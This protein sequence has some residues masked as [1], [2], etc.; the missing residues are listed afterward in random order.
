[1]FARTDRLLLR[2][3]FA[4]DAVE[5]AAAIGD[6]AVV[7]NLARAPWPYG[8]D[9]ARQFLSLDRPALMPDFV[10]MLRTSATPRLIGCVG[11]APGED[12]AVEF[13]YWI[14]RTHWGLGFASEAARAALTIGRTIGHRRIEAAHYVDNPASGAVLRKLGFRP[15]GRIVQRHSVARGGTVAAVE[16]R[17][18][19]GEGGVAPSPAMRCRVHPDDD[20]RQQIRLIAA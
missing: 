9:D 20:M 14:A 19:D 6:E 16:H 8:V 2:P 12:G 18:D 5:L 1:M 13:G 10:I 3:G 15:T 7:R 11:F 17:L 4:E